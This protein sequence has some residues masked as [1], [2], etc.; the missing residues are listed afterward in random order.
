MGRVVDSERRF[1]KISGLRAWMVRR[2]LPAANRSEKAD[3]D[4]QLTAGAKEAKWT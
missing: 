1:A 3:S 4:P 2:R